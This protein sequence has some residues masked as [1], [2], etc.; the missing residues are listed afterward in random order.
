[1][2][3]SEKLPMFV[4]LSDYDDQM[5][6]DAF[7]KYNLM[8]TPLSSCRCGCSGKKLQQGSSYA[9]VDICQVLSHVILTEKETRGLDQTLTM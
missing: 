9:C 3:H 5:I 4:Y 2:A 1:V 8:E 6:I 7:N